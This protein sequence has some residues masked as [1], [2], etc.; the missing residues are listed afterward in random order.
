MAYRVV[1]A[2]SAIVGSIGVQSAL[3][4]DEEDGEIRFVSSQSPEDRIILFL[5]PCLNHVHQVGHQ[6]QE[7]LLKTNLVEHHLRGHK[8]S[9]RE[10][11]AFLDVLGALTAPAT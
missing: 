3:R 6:C 10:H 1:A 4:A 2:D 11:Y 9:P 7:L 5:R 8:Y